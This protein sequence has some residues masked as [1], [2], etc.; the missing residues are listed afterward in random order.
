M[1]IEKFINSFLLLVLLLL[2]LLVLYS[3]LNWF[4]HHGTVLNTLSDTQKAR[5]LRSLV[6]LLEFQYDRTQIEPSHQTLPLLNATEFVNILN[7][8]L[9]SDDQQHHSNAL[10]TQWV[11]LNII[12]K[13]AEW[14]ILDNIPTCDDGEFLMC[15]WHKLL[16]SYDTNGSRSNDDGIDGSGRCC[17]SIGSQFNWTEIIR[18]LSHSIYGYP[19]NIEHRHGGVC[20]CKRAQIDWKGATLLLISFDSISNG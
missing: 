2:L 10:D 12:T 11:V 19:T 16:N 14:L 13:I 8:I 5:L 6:Q 4:N 7:L 1:S 9:S 3:Y 20:K 17:N 18:L 15:V